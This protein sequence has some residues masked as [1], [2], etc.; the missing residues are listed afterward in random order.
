MSYGEGPEFP[1]E[2]LITFTVHLGIGV[3]GNTGCKQSW[4]VTFSIRVPNHS[5]RKKLCFQFSSTNEHCVW[6][7]KNCFGNDN[8]TSTVLGS[9]MQWVQSV[10]FQTVGIEILFPHVCGIE[11]LSHHKQNYFLEGQGL[12]FTGSSMLKSKIYDMN[13]R[14]RPL[15]LTTYHS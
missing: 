12:N 3:T 10:K 8:E 15:S 11:K 5:T 13:Y 14:V 9:S 4:R 2:F 1:Y 7:L 6:Q